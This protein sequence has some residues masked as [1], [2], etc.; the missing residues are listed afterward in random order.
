[1]L[2]RAFLHAGVRL[3][4][5]LVFL[6]LASP[7]FAQVPEDIAIGAI[8]WDAWFDGAND[9]KVLE[10]PEWRHRAP[11]F[12]RYDEKGKVHL[13]GDKEYVLHAEVAYARAIGL[14]YFI[15]GYY[16]DTGSWG[17][18]PVFHRKL[19]GALSAYLKLPDRMG[20]KFA[21]S[22][23]QLFPLDDVPAMAR[24]LANFAAHK[25]YMVTQTGTLPVFIL[26]HDG[27]DWS[28]AFGSDDKA[29]G[30]IQTLRKAVRDRTGKEITFVLMHY[31]SGKAWDTARRYGLDM[32]T[33]YSN[34]A[35][36]KGAVQQEASACILHG[37]EVWRRAAQDRVPYAPNITL[38]WDDRPRKSLASYKASTQGPWC[39]L[40]ASNDLKRQF[41]SA[42]SF[43][44]TYETSTPFR[45][46]TIYAWN[47][48][49]EGGWMA[50]NK[51]RGKDWMDDQR[52]AVGRNRALSSTTITVPADKY[53]FKCIPQAPSA[54]RKNPDFYCHTDQIYGWPCPAGLKP[55]GRYYQVNRRANATSE[56][57]FEI[58]IECSI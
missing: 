21:I 17:R 57:A 33:T 31:L 48:Y 12:A 15:F 46:I 44:R 35:P 55:S 5:M 32:V 7:A 41:A 49:T 24:N 22:F 51:S 54:A 1:M 50:P 43:I 9:Q 3:Q 4:A 13:D 6:L 10:Q 47:E 14:D 39:K 30:V 20:V 34:F 25:D 56:N 29:R 45:T 18:D 16:P 8:R 36:G 23:N 42:V 27:L 38:G 40:P 37:Q 52:A 58:K 2:L 11:F 19:N 26:G 28:K 53:S